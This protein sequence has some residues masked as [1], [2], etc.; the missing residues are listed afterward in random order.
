MVCKCTLLKR[1]HINSIE[2]YHF[3]QLSHFGTT[4]NCF[5]GRI[6][7]LK[8]YIGVWK[9]PDLLT[10]FWARQQQNRTG[11]GKNGNRDKKEK[12]RERIILT[13]LCY[14]ILSC[15]SAYTISTTQQ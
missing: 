3:Q 6:L 1:N 10:K 5:A 9:S 15:L 12:R 11:K 7:E 4:K 8:I 2:L 14:L 13:H